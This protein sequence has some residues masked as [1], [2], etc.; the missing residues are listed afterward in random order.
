MKSVELTTE[1]SLKAMVIIKILVT[2]TCPS[3]RRCSSRRWTVRK[4]QR[5]QACRPCTNQ[6]YQDI[7]EG[8]KNFHFCYY[9]VEYCE[10]F[11]LVHNNSCDYS[12]D[13][14]K[15]KGDQDGQELA[16]SLFMKMVRI[17][18]KVAMMM[19][20]IEVMEPNALCCQIHDGLSPSNA[21]IN[22]QLTG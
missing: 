5:G 4:Q 12:S 19:A 18:A 17:I 10:I 20:R 13:N 11:D 6:F 2:F 16:Q 21:S 1:K 22:Q 3:S 7:I 15:A 14:C 9:S 8:H